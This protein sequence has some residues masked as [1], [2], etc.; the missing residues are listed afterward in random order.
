M[1]ERAQQP[2]VDEPPIEEFEERKQDEIVQRAAVG[3][4][5]VHDAIMLEGLD[6]LER[7]APALAWSG[8]AAG[9]SLGFSFATE[10]ALTMRLPAT[11]WAGLVNSLG[12]SMGFLI[13][14]LGR[15]QLFTE[16][17]LTVVLPLLV[18]RDR[19]TLRKMLRLWTI[20]FFTNVL[21]AMLF[22]WAAT[23]TSVFGADMQATFHNMAA[24]HAALDAGSNFLRAIFAGWLIALMVWLLPVAQHSGPQI[25]ILLTWLIGVLHLTHVIA[26]SVVIFYAWFTGITSMSQCFLGFLLPALIGNI[27]GG[28][29][30][31]A[32]L[33]HNQARA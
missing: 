13:V 2:A 11:S 19:E 21:G 4:D 5:I 28:V 3:A 9:L 31:V 32:L 18:R 33:N 23:W 22:A 12:Y 1:S 7:S 16:T 29:A 25:V 14:V 27:I 8:L 17:T 24:D 30:L 20:V 6:E 15:Q 10:A 26:G